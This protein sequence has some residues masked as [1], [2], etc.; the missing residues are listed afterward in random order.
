MYILQILVFA[1]FAMMAKHLVLS[2]EWANA[3]ATTIQETSNAFDMATT[4]L[5]S[6][7]AN[8]GSKLSKLAKIG[9][10]L[11]GAFGVF[12]AL[13]S[14]VLAF[15][16]GS[17]SPELTLMKSEFGKLSESVDKVARSLEDTKGLIKL[18][19]Q[20]TAYIT[21]E[22]V[23]HNGYS[24]LQ[25]CLK[26]LE[27]V[28]CSNKT[29]CKRKKMLVAQGYT[30]SM[31]VQQSLATV[32]RGV[33]S[34]TAFGKS[35][36]DLLKENSKCNVPKI[37]LF[38]NKVTAL[39]TKGITVAIFHD[40]L[41]KTGY[42]V[43]DGAVVGDGMLRS[44]ESKRQTIQHKCFENFDYWMP[45]D[46]VNLHDQFS[47]NIQNTNTKLLNTLKTKYPWIHWHAVTYAGESGPVSGPSSSTRRLLYSSSKNH[48]VH[49]FVIPTNDA[50]VENMPDKIAQ[51]KRIVQIDNIDWT[52]T[53]SAIENQVRSDMVIKNQV[54]SFAIL[55]G[56]RSIFGHYGTEVKQHTLGGI[57]VKTMNVFVHKPRSGYIVVV[58]FTQADYPPSCTD[59]CNGKGKCFVYP[60]SIQTGC[61]CDLG[62]D[63]QKCES[64]GMGLKLKSVINNILDDTMKLPTFA[65]IQHSIEDTQLYLKTST[66]N[67][68][69]SIMQLGAKIDKQFKS[70]GEF[71]SNKFDWFAVLL[72]YKDAIENLNY[73][74]SISS[75]KIVHFRKD[76]DF[77]IANETSNQTEVHFAMNQ[78]K[79]IA[80]YLLSP[81]GIQKWLYQI[82]F[83]IV[84]RRDSEFNSHKPLLFMVMDKYKDRICSQ[85]Y[86]D[87]ITRTYR[88]LMLLQL[89][90][91][92]LWSNA[93]SIVNRDSSMI[94]DRYKAILKDQQTYLQKATCGVAIP[95]S[96]NLQSCTGG[97]YIPN[98]Q[99][100]ELSCAKGYIKKGR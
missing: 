100:V 9:S 72:K 3:A 16:P 33:T 57:E 54:Q 85:T 10:K 92:L 35:L 55:P 52:R 75:E 89:Q 66:E 47:S 67:I 36:L 77:K 4:A 26:K 14:I 84:G 93:Y 19:T 5:E 39:I 31:K 6:F 98:S 28:P 30:S 38:V 44:L 2:E 71:M 97:Y 43:L 73:F 29:D 79:D 53:A 90:G 95:H 83:L 41:T 68:Q 32:F 78:G 51:W 21:H 8:A 74:H 50:E 58:S 46:V 48:N 94:A 7:D 12:G 1:I 88:Q 15:I 22:N 17:E 60:Y 49:S 64:S 87:E 76:F 11:T 63:G 59:T 45:L 99:P 18:A 24:Q 20:R 70:L 13:F 65:S 96:K 69:K 42:N 23:I 56:D 37:N 62:Y 40:M 91:Y 27:N 82:N 80:S 86:K 25:E 61:R 34:N 81:A